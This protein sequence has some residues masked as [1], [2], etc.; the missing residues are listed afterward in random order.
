[1][2]SNHRDIIVVPLLVWAALLVLVL[3]SLGYACWPGA[4]ARFAFGLGIAAIK[5]AL[6]GLVFMQLRRASGLVRIA[7]L[8]GLFFLSLLF[9]FSFADFLTR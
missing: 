4:P 5:S 8:A 9:F 6:I 3:V 1:M 7:S 2:D